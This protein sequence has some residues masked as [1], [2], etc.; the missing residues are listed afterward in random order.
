MER[1]NA[2]LDDVAQRLCDWLNN[3]IPGQHPLAVAGGVMSGSRQ[4]PTLP[5]DR[6]VGPEVLLMVAAGGAGGA[7]VDKGNDKKCDYWALCNMAGV[8]CTLCK[9]KNGFDGKK[10]K[11]P[12]GTVVGLNWTGCCPDGG[13]T[14]RWID[15]T[16]CCH[17][18]EDYKGC[19]EK[20][21][22]KNYKPGVNWCAGKGNYYCT[23]AEH[24]P[25]KDASC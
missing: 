22:C 12:S 2:W 7:V 5:V 1:M 21:W 25:K 19:S 15:F 8:P 14:K 11:C 20:C 10:G 18:T 4:C 6:R 17:K 3:H 23:I 13:G 9:G 16:D 24:D